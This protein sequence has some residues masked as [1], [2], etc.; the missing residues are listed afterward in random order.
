MIRLAVFLTLAFFWPWRRPTACGQS[1][2]S[3]P[4]APSMSE[5]PIAPKDKKAN[6]RVRVA[7]G[8]RRDGAQWRGEMVDLWKR[9][10]RVNDNGVLSRSLLDSGADPYPWYFD[11]D[12]LEYRALDAADRKTAISVHTKQ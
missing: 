8:T 9:K 5:S 11:R 12:Q 1:P 7:L 3:G 2:P 6:V 10:F 4:V